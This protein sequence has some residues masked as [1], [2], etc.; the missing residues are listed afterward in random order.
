M[1]LKENLK[2]EL[3]LLLELDQ[4]N[5]P[6][7]VKNTPTAQAIIT[8]RILGLV[9]ETG[10]DKPI[11]LLYI[12]LS[13]DPEKLQSREENSSGKYPFS[14]SSYQST[15]PAFPHE[16]TTDIKY[17]PEQYRAYRDLGY[18][19]ANSPALPKFTEG[20]K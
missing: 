6:I 15:H 4:P 10:R 17:S 19:I 3:G 12:K 5:G 9:D 7:N 13:M 16:S 20:V 1:R 2:N 8:G 14:V 11:E 18:T